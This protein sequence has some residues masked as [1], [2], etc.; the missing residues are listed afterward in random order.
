MKGW[1]AKSGPS[2][3]QILHITQSHSTFSNFFYKN[4]LSKTRKY[5]KNLWWTPASVNVYFQLFTTH[6]FTNSNIG[7]TGGPDRRSSVLKEEAIGIFCKKISPKLQKVDLG[8]CVVRNHHMQI[9]VKRCKNVTELRLHAT[10]LEN[11]DCVDVIIKGFFKTLIKLEL[12]YSISFSAM[13]GRGNPRGIG[14]PKLCLADLP[15]LK[16]FWFRPNSLTVDEEETLRQILP[17]VVINQRGFKVSDPKVAFWDI[18]CKRSD[19][20]EVC[21][22]TD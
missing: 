8:G 7:G 19:M 12:P 18:K 11:N 15:N 9:L 4:N 13:Q 10:Q 20:F 21:V 17:K 3:S 14:P 16:Y 6:Y 2:F 5:R 22:K 1:V